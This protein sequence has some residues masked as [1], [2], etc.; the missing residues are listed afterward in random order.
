[1][2]KK[3]LYIYEDMETEF[4]AITTEKG[5]LNKANEYLTKYR[6]DGEYGNYLAEVESIKGKNNIDDIET[7]IDMLGY[8]EIEVE[9]LTDFWKE[10]KKD[11]FVVLA[12]KKDHILRQ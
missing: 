7:A 1:M 3:K 6:K 5:I 10:I 9:L 11:D 2:E 8:M 12:G 4:V